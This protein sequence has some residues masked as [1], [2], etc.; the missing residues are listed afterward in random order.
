MSDAK[1]LV[2][3][4]RNYGRRRHA[5]CKEAADMIEQQQA[6]IV[7]YKHRID[8]LHNAVQIEREAANKAMGALDLIVATAK[9]GRGD[10]ETS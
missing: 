7:S 9:T 5:V 8:L 3:R 4:L 6:D 2:E 1:E 10:D